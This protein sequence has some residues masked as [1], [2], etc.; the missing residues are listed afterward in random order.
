MSAIVLSNAF[1]GSV[2][3]PK[4]AQNS[5]AFLNGNA[6]FSSASNRLKY[7]FLGLKFLI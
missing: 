6:F 3:K 1:P 4:P 5:E 2:L 7:E